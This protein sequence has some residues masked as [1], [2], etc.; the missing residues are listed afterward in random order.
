MTAAKEKHDTREDLR[1]T[2]LEGLA[3]AAECLRA[4]G[5]PVRLR[6]VEVLM[7]GEF[8]VKDLAALCE[9][10]PHMMSEHLRLLQAR[11]MLTARRQGREVYYRIAD[12]RLPTLIGCI[13]L[14]CDR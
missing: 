3:E 9:L 2:S 8:P 7:Q 13:Q 10:P 12:P 5:H 6:L 4:L 14:H 1:L 11:G